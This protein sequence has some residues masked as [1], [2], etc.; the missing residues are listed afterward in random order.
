MWRQGTHG[1]KAVARALGRNDGYLAGVGRPC[2]GANGRVRGCRLCARGRMQATTAKGGAT[3]CGSRRSR[4]ARQLAAVGPKLRTPTR[5]TAP[6]G[7][8]DCGVG[9]RAVNWRWAGRLP[10][11]SRIRRR[12]GVVGEV[13][14]YAVDCPCGRGRLRRDQR[15]VAGRWLADCPMSPLTA[16]GLGHVGVGDA[17]RCVLRCVAA[18]GCRRSRSAQRGVSSLA[19]VGRPPTSRGRAWGDGWHERC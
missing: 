2:R 1:A 9:R 10:D 7:A 19:M 14:A 16:Q 11:G 18:A 17:D 5:L 8:V 13:G 15:A 12:Q 3:S 4:T 6:G